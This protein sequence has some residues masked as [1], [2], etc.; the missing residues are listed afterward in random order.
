[1]KLSNGDISGP[2]VCASCGDNRQLANHS[3][4]FETASRPMNAAYLFA[5]LQVNNCL[6]AVIAA[7]KLAIYFY[8][9]YNPTM[10]ND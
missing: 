5:W 10:E 1:M 8:T 9:I 6:V 3:M 7:I 2:I 4:I